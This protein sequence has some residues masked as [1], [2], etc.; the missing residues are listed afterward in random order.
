MQLL[1]GKLFLRRTTYGTIGN[2]GGN[3]RATSGGNGPRSS[4]KV[5]VKS[6]VLFLALYHVY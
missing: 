3:E 2:S 4:C 5:F 1:G 6:V